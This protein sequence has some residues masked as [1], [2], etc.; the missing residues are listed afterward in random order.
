MDTSFSHTGVDNEHVTSS[1]TSRR[2]CSRQTESIRRV[3]AAE[4]SFAALVLDFIL[5]T[6]PRVPI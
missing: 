3:P 4:L 6:S 2:L 1:D 5:V